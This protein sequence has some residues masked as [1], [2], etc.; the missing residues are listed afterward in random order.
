MNVTGV[1]SNAVESG[2]G[3]AFYF[4]FSGCGTRGKRNLLLDGYKGGEN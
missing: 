2:V 3:S 1:H 4:S